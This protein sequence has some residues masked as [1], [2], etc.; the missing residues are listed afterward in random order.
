M[1]KLYLMILGIS[2]I[3]TFSYAQEVDL[4]SEIVSST[5]VLSD[6]SKSSAKETPE[7]YETQPDE[8][9]VADD[10]GI[11]SFLNFSFIKKPLSLFS[12]DEEEP[13]QSDSTEP[14]IKETPLQRQIRHANEGNV[15]AQLALGYMYL[16]GENGVEKDFEQAF[17][18]YEMA[19]LQ[20]NPIALNNLGSL[21]FNGIGTERNYLKAAQ[22][23]SDAAQ[24]GSDD[25]AVNLAFIYLSSKNNET[26][27][28]E[29]VKLFI[30]ASQAGNKTGTFM[31]G[32]AYYQ[33]FQVEQNLHKANELMK[34][35]AQAEFD[36]GEYELALMYLKGDGI[37]QNYGN[38]VKYLRQ[39]AAQ[40]N[41]EATMLLAK[42]FE[43]GAVFPQNLKRA[44]V[45]Y[46]IAAI[47]NV[48][49]AAQK[50]DEVA[51]KLKIEQL[52]EAQTEAEAFKASPSELTSYIRQT[53][54][55][56]IRRYID[57]NM[58]K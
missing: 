24:N 50:R 16:Y 43:E 1:K 42:I 22:M 9:Q 54:G 14:Q 46:N 36:E 20:K 34:A 41:L 57:D 5:P 26:F 32:Y 47:D 8:E 52:L 7:A 11:F 44:H 29:A 6:S 27:L 21:Y 55:Q 35:A 18:F 37:A 56:N 23:F 10:R 38:A 48:K 58:K 12:S 30:Q 4:A 53:F 51:Q 15:D 3:G 19:A 39:A 45:L 33:G 49:G 25:A 2:L 31:L 40:G 17:K 13:T 28:P